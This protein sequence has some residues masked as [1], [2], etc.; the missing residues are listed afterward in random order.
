MRA[1]A[2]V[3]PA[4]KRFVNIGVGAVLNKHGYTTSLTSAVKS[5]DAEK[6]DP[7]RSG[8]PQREKAP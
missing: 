7:R 4:A 8:A 3:K 6:S 1:V 5:R 2:D